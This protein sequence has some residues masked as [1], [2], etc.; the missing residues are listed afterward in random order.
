MRSSSAFTLVEL[1]VV[2]AIIGIL[3]A[4][5]LPAVQ[6]AREAARRSQCSNNLKQTCL[7]LHNFESATKTVASGAF[8][9]SGVGG[10]PFGT[11]VFLAQYMEL[12]TI[13]QTMNLKTVDAWTAPNDAA[14]YTKPQAF[15]CPTDPSPG[16]VEAMGFTNYHGNWGTWSPATGWDGVFG[17]CDDLTGIKRLPS[18]KFGDVIDGLSNTAAFSEVVNGAGGAGS[19]KTKFDCLDFGSQPSTTDLAAARTALMAKDWN[20]ASMLW[21]PPWRWRGTPWTE[22]SV[23]R[24]GYNHLLTP[25]S[26]CWQTGDWF[27]LVTPASSYHPGGVQVGL[28]DGSVRFVSESVDW[29]AWRALGTR[30]GGESIAAP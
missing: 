20:Q 5:L 3:I 23:W 12:T 10:T 2:I 22:G 27:H 15:L 8:L 24:T 30:A 14:L 16:K 29:N 26:P 21:D 17:H 28:M 19:A 13:T 25:N 9:P 7:A 1:L 11:L 18:L 6:A 4:L